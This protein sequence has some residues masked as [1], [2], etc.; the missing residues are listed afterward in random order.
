M[1][2]N[3]YIAG[4]RHDDDPEVH[5]GKRSAAGLY[6]W[7]CKVSLHRRGERHV[8]DGP[9]G[10]KF[11]GLRSLMAHDRSIDWHDACPKCGGAEAEETMEE[12]SAGRELGFNTSE[13]ARKSGVRS[14]ASFSWAMDPSRLDDIDRIEDEYGT[15]YSRSDFLR[16]VLAECPIRF[17][18]SIGTWFS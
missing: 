18:D 8:H 2:T 15:E 1:G 13:P 17:H 9:T 3:Y 16:K 6:C 5:I 11:T 7:D 4:H 12:S 10:L 14:C